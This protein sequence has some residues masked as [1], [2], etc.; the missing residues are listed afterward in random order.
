MKKKEASFW[1][2]IKILDDRLK[3]EPDSFCFARLSEIYLKVGLVAD[4]LH[5]ARAG[6]AKHPGYLAGQRA[7]GMACNASGLHDEC[8]VVLE[9]VAA[10]MPEDVD[11]QKLLASLY[12]AAG[13]HVSAIRTYRTVLDFRPDDKVCAMELEALQHSGTSS[14]SVSSATGQVEAESDA[15]YQESNEDEIIELKE[16]DILEESPEEKL[17]VVT[18][19]VVA[20]A[21]SD[22]HDPLSTLTLAELYEQQGFLSKALEIYRTILADDPANTQLLAKISRLEEPESVPEKLPLEAASEDVYEEPDMSEPVSC[23]EVPAALKSQLLEPVT[24]NIAGDF[25]PEPS[26]SPLTEVVPAPLESDLVLPVFENSFDAVEPD[27]PAAETYEVASTTLESKAF[28]PLSHKAADNVVETLDVW[29]EN[30]RRIK[31]CR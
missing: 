14:S 15:F 21:G 12:V 20:G 16:S 8:R 31:A 4:A 11:A 28:A 25:E 30:I 27:L 26:V 23:E 6:V 7:L 10:A 22:H 3:R 13:D 5:T 1:S 18:P 29:L 24:E 9:Q 19:A 2:D 17:K